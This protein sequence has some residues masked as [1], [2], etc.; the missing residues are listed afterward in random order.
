[1]FPGRAWDWANIARKRHKGGELQ[2]EAYVLLK[3]SGLHFVGNV[4]ARE[5]PEDAADVVVAD[6]FTG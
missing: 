6:G 1:M 2:Q 5:I 3:E 4:E